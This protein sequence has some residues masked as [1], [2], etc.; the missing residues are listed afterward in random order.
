MSEDT[1]GRIVLRVAVLRVGCY[2]RVSTE[3]QALKGFSIDAQIDNLEEHCKKHKMKI[4]GHYTDEGISGAKPPLKRPALQRLLDDVVAGKIDMILFTKLD[5]WFRS[6]QEY[7]K[8]QEIL[9]RHRVEWKAIHEDYDT[10]TAN[11]RMAITIFLAIAQNER[12]KTAE[13]I[14]VVLEHKRKNR[15]ACFGGPNLSM[16]YRKY[17]DDEGYLRLEKDPEY[18]E[19][20]NHFWGVVK[21]DYNVKKAIREVGQIYG[22]FRDEKAWYRIAHSELYCGIY[23]GVDNYCEPYVSKED[24][25]LV[26]ERTTGQRCAVGN[27]VYLFTGL[28]RCPKC[29]HILCGTYDNKVYLGV[30]KE[31]RHYRC[32]HKGTQRCDYRRSLSELKMEKHL[33]T[34]LDKY[35]E[36]EIARVELEK[37]MPKPKPKYNLPA[38]KEQLRRLEVVYLAGNK[39]DAEYL[40]ETKEIKALIEKAEN[41]APPPDRDV[42]PLKELLETD[43]KK[44]YYSLEPAERKRFWRGLIKEIVL[45]DNQVKEV[46]FF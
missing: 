41:E 24:W 44:I 10:T 27:R 22:V 42:E 9:E 17:R 40:A 1:K 34:N 39:S 12:E 13:R 35:L 5:R 43:F 45:E 3:E 30:K 11:G 38:L 19:I 46:I 16:G 21:R 28:M 36:D 33:I 2:E 26:Q 18:E 23:K 6:V 15:E 20:I 32:R 31:Y 37:T 8:V 4:V 14:K 29:G 7:F 25:L